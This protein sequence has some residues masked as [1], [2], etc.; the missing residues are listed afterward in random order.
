MG[1][2]DFLRKGKEEK[3]AFQEENLKRLEG[4]FDPTGAL[5]LNLPRFR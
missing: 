1:L 5:K 4:E 2:F 3:R